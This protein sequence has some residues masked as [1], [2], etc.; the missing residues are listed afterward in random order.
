MCHLSI[1]D[2]MVGQ[3]ELSKAYIYEGNTTLDFPVPLSRSIHAM[4]RISF[5]RSLYYR[6]GHRANFKK[7]IVDCPHPK[8]RKWWII[9]IAINNSNYNT[10]HTLSLSDSQHYNSSHHKENIYVIT[11][12]TQRSKNA[13]Q[14]LAS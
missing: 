3:Q 7:E 13:S 2:C 14:N 4:E 1:N 5:N 11:T 8:W 12:I 6:L 10:Q 9:R